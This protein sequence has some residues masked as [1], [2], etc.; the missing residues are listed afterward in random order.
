MALEEIAQ[1]TWTISSTASTL[2]SAS[3]KS[4]FLLS[5][6][7]CE[8]L[9]SLTIPLSIFLQNKSSDLVS[10]VK[11]TNEVLSSLRQ[12][13]E[14]ANDTFTEIFQVASTFSA[15]LFDN[16]L[17]APRVTSRQKS[18]ANPQ[19]TSN[20]EYFRVTTFIPCVD[21]LIQNL[22]DRFVKNEYILSNFKLL[23]P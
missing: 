12:M 19:T 23:L 6:V 5:I 10:A 1:R 7:V 20:E 2:H 21:T 22:T 17:Q 16:E 14:T 11:Y 18:R 4:E 9:F 13:R 8:K 3:Q 15:N